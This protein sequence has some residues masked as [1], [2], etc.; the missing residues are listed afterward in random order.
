MRW[1]SSTTGQNPIARS[2]PLSRA[3]SFYSYPLKLDTGLRQATQGQGFVEYYCEHGD[4]HTPSDSEEG[5]AMSVDYH[6]ALRPRSPLRKPDAQVSQLSKSKTFTLITRPRGWDTFSAQVANPLMLFDGG[7][8][9][10]GG[11]MHPPSP[12]G[13]FAERLLPPIML[14]GVTTSSDS[15]CRCRT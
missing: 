14:E 9:T 5:Q 7:E 3:H 11:N 13:T 12:I 6:D 4:R 10:T 1:D 8:N 2:N 15:L